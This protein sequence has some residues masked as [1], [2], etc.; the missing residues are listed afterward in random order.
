LDKVLIV[1]DDLEF[2]N[3]LKEGLDKYKGQFEVLTAPDGEEATEVLKRERISVL[4]T[5]LVMQKVGGQDLL[6]HMTKNYPQIPCIVI[7]GA[8]SHEIK[9][10]A[11]RKDILCYIEKPF[12]F[13]E[14][15][16]A[17]I[18]GLDR[19][20]EGVFWQKCKTEKVVC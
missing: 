17:V 9:K 5:D 2:L 13:E 12:A 11:Y 8:G 20:D 6:T 14:L 7:T 19:L 10:S 3:T 16:W 18:D 15:A 1:D 4:V